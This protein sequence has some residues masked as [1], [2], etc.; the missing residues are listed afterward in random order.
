MLADDAE[1]ALDLEGADVLVGAGG[2]ALGRREAAAGAEEAGTEVAGTA[3][4][5]DP[6]GATLGSGGAA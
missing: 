2:C 1:G 3:A 4:A 5:L 6:G